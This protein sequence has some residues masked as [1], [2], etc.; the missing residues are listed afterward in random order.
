MRMAGKFDVSMMDHP[1]RIPFQSENQTLTA[2]YITRCA[3]A[4]KVRKEPIVSCAARR[5]DDLKPPKPAVQDV[6]EPVVA[7]ANHIS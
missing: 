3:K 2:L 5:M 1:I 7:A 6:W 4:A